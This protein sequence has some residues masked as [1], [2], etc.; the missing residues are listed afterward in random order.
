MKQIKLLNLVLTN[1]K[2]IKEFELNAEGNVSIHGDNATGKTTIADAFIWLLFD[3]D[4]NNQK[5]FGIK[6]L[7]NGKPIPKLNH[8]VEAT[9]VV[10]DKQLT[11][12]KVFSEKWTKK[13]G[14]ITSEFSGHT[15]DHYID[16]VPSNKKGFTD[17]VASIVDEDI[18]KLLTSPSYFNEQ[19]RWKKRRDLLLE[20]AGDVSDEEVINSNK[21]LSKLTDILSGRNIE[22]HKKV[23]AAKRKEINQELEKIPVRVD[24]IYRGLPDVNGLNKSSI[25]KQ[26]TEL[27]DQIESKQEQVNDIRGGSEVN[28]LKQQISD[29]DLQIANIKNEHAQNGQD[30]VY[31]L[32]TKLQEEQ[33]N[34]TVLQSKINSKKQQ[35]SMNKDYIDDLIDRRADLRKRYDEKDSEAFNHEENCSCPSCGQDLPEEQRE[36]IIKTFNVNKAEM[37]EHIKAKGVET[38]D[39]IKAT[40]TENQTVA[41]DIGKLEKQ[42]TEKQEQVAKLEAKLTESQ[43][44]VKP[45]EDNASYQKLMQD[46]QALEQQIEELKQS[47]EKSVQEVKQEITELNEKQNEVNIDL[48]KVSQS[49]QSKTRIAELEKQEKELAAEFEQLE[50][51]LHLTEEFIRTKVNMLEEKINSKFKDARFNLFKTNINGGLEEICTTTLDGVPYN[52][53]LNN[54]ARINVGLDIINTLSQHYG[55]QAPIFVDNAESV[56]RLIDI[57]SQVISLV[58]SEADKELRIENAKEMELV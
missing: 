31:K 6:T 20:I 51:E 14:S 27:N 34:I 52:A 41:E 18:F 57:D 13:R 47:V 21:D 19:L 32:R 11:L 5:D 50:E 24:E 30:E 28:K 10:D 12:K 4:S 43:S 29:I 45:I 9:I 49:E 2:G 35:H 3:K 26:L 1:F 48:S 25:E 7:E 44:N 55:V 23:I 42:V 17:Q 15:T 46:R 53:G 39:K 36:E 22:D 40:G 37:L 58:V 16:G 33:S 38:N 8:E 54:A 56:T